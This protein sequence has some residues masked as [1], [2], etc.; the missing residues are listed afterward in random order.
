MTSDKLPGTSAAVA[1]SPGGLSSG[2]SAA[3]LK[4][5]APDGVHVEAD[6]VAVLASLDAEVL[7]G[8]AADSGST[9]AADAGIR[10]PVCDSDF[11][12]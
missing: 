12:C 4:K 9:A 7:H 6:D 2:A 10:E 11:G 8:S 1:V 5:L 3:D